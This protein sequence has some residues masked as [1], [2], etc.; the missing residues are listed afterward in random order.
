MD[1]ERIYI[2]QELAKGGDVLDRLTKRETYT[3]HDVRELAFLLLKTMQTL[4]GRQ[5]VHRDL[6]PE[7]LLLKDELDDTQILLCDFGYATFLPPSE[8]SPEPSSITSEGEDGDYRSNYY[9][10]SFVGSSPYMAPEIVVGK[11]Y[12]EEV[13]MWSVGCILYML[14]SG[15]PPFGEED[16]SFLFDRIQQSD[17]EFHH[18][19]WENI[20]ANAKC[21]ISNL[22]TVDQK[23]RWTAS[24][25]LQS[26]WFTNDES[27]NNNTTIL[28]QVNLRPS[29][30]RME[31]TRKTKS[32]RR[33]RSQNSQNLSLGKNNGEGNNNN[34]NDVSTSSESDDDVAPLPA[35]PASGSASFDEHT[36]C[37]ST[38][39]SISGENNIKNTTTT[40]TTRKVAVVT[41]STPCT[42]T[43]DA[44]IKMEQTSSRIQ[45]PSEKKKAAEKKNNCLNIHNNGRDT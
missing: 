44:N 36:S 16:D 34:G 22:L 25:A 14:L 32:I 6:K 11:N 12:R 18:E 8:P 35:P 26:N 24:K 45:P 21:L 5:I 28:Q 3:E 10:S 37:A 2:V 33:T 29:L 7:N 4:H 20:T 1:D 17:Y 15:N 40:T 38:I 9:L 30:T 41:K 42:T 31:N 23:D 19:C 13:D 43:L 39:I 27:N